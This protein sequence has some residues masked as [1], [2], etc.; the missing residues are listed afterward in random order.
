[1]RRIENDCC[2]CATDT[3]PC[4]GSLCPLLKAEHIYCDKC[5]HELTGDVFFTHDGED[6]CPDCIIDALIE[7]GIIEREDHSI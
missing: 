3:Y 4:R 1:M 6:L 5:K 2:S 7:G